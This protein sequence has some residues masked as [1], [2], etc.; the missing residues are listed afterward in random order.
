MDNPTA[1]AILLLSILVLDVLLLFFGIKKQFAD[2][3]LDLWLLGHENKGPKRPYD[4]PESKKNVAINYDLFRPKNLIFIRHKHFII[5]FSLLTFSVISTWLLFIIFPATPD[6]PNIVTVFAG[7]FGI[8][9]GSIG[10][11]ELLP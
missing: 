3:Y 6:A 2:K 11:H 4:M 7:V 8:I 5:F 1:Q 10:L 9:I